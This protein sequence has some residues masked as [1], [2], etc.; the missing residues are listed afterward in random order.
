MHHNITIA[1]IAGK[2][3]ARAALAQPNATPQPV[4]NSARFDA[5]RSA[6]LRSGVA[7]PPPPPQSSDKRALAFGLAAA[8]SFVVLLA[9]AFAGFVLARRHGNCG[10]AQRVAANNKQTSA[11]SL[12]TTTEAAT[13]HRSGLSACFEAGRAEAAD[14]STFASNRAVQDHVPKTAMVRLC[15][16]SKR[17]Q[18]SCESRQSRS[19]RAS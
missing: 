18:K 9:A 13:R 17:P 14:T 6:P 3:Q 1:G 11:G 2:L 8:L 19:E 4:D 10:G 16:F 12:G 15:S 5:R 7:T